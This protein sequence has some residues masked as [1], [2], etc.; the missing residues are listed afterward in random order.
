[1]Q[2]LMLPAQVL[3]LIPNPI[4][5]EVILQSPVGT[6]P[7]LLI[8]Q[9]PAQT[10]LHLIQLITARIKRQQLMAPLRPV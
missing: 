2:C 7:A 6:N 5:R 4:M 3:Q 9:D 10:P 8:S 1:M